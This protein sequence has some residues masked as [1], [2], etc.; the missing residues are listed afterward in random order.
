LKDK[1]QAAKRQKVFVAGRGSTVLT[2][3]QE[4][5]SINYR[6]KT[7]ESRA[8]YEELMAFVQVQQKVISVNPLYMQLV[9]LRHINWL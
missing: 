3:T 1:A 2:E 9:V 6:P 7:R 4:M 8:A 5:D